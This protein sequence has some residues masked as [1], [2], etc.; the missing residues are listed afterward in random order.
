MYVGGLKPHIAIDVR[1][2][3]PR[4][5]TQA[6]SLARPYEERNSTNAS[7]PRGPAK[8]GATST[9]PYPKIRRLSPS[10]VVDRRVK[11]LCF[12]CDEPYNPGHKCAKVFSIEVWQEE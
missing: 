4:D 1:I 5:L 10:E 2:A 7:E 12:R 3:K 11:G 9:N 8:G 6:M